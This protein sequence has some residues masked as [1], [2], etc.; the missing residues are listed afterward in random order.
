MGRPSPEQSYRVGTG[1]MVLDIRLLGIFD[2]LVDG[3]SVALGPA[4]QRALLASLAVD[5]GRPV[6]V[7]ALVDRIWDDAPPTEARKALHTYVTRTRRVLEQMRPAADGELDLQRRP[8]GYQL[9]VDPDLVDLHRFHRLVDRARGLD[10]HDPHRARLLAEAVDL[11]R[12]EALAGLSGAW[13]A[14]L[15]EGLGQQ[16]LSALADWAEAELAL[17]H[18]RVVIDRLQHVVPEHPLAE[19]LVARLIQALHMAGRDAEALDAYALARQRI[20]DG[21]GA[22]PGPELRRLHGAVLRGEPVVADAAPTASRP[23]AVAASPGAAGRRVPASAYRQLPPDIANFTGRRAEL[24]ALRSTATAT[25]GTAVAVSV[26]EGMAGVGK[27]KFAVHAAHRLVAEGR[28]PDGQIYVDLHGYSA[29]GPTDPAT[30]LALLLRL[31]GVATDDLPGDLAARSAVFRDRLAGRHT[32]II[33]D[34]AADET[35]LAPL[36]PGSPTCLVVVTSRRCLAIE[37]AQTIRLPA[38]TAD[39]AVDL[40]AAV[41]GVARVTAEPTAARELVAHCGHLPLAVAVAAQRLRNRPA[42]PI[43]HL[44]DRLADDHRRLD[45]L[46]QGNRAVEAV[47]ALSYNALGPDRRRLFRLLG[48]HPGHDFTAASAAALAGADPADVDRDLES[49][50]D[51][52][53]LQQ[54]VPGRYQIHDLLRGYAAR[55][56][57]AEDGDAAREAAISRLLDWYLHATDAAT[58]L[59]R[60]FAVPFTRAVAAPKAPGPDLTG[61]DDALDWLDTEYANLV[62]AAR[63]AAAGPWPAHAVQFPHL[64]LPY[65]VKRSQVEDWIALLHLAL[66][67]ADRLD[68]AHA[69]AHTLT[70]LG[71]ACNTAGRT[72]EGLA[73]LDQALD[74]H[75]RLGD[76]YGKAITLNHLGTVHRRLGDHA[77]AA[78]QYATALDL[79]R[80]TGDDVRQASTQSNLSVELHLLGRHEEALDHAGQALALQRR[81]GGPGEASLRT[82]LGL[83]YSRLGRHAEAV[84]HSLAALALHRRAASGPGETNALANLC[85]SYARLGEHDAA[86]EAGVRALDIARCLAD[87]DTVV[88]ALNTLGEAYHLAGDDS[89][90]LA[91]HREAL[92]VAV[93]IGDADERSRARLGMAAATRRSSAMTRR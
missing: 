81:L 92:A 5:A 37:G 88:V 12:G 73:H 25:P 20:A 78:D 31:L 54:S 76:A 21:I 70:D 84:E 1:A 7:E 89:R 64:L 27:T 56:C 47:F 63:T 55:R 93:R 50:L 74:L 69:R 6:V 65:L 30:V 52:H 3:R 26:V 85:H 33:L 60:R 17:G 44:R 75:D 62:A 22:E 59:I 46:V 13:A 41:A 58:S 9:V 2:V 34:N 19:S 86:V 29:V 4:K 14:R 79:F 53:L 77:R 91:H 28:Y 61:P 49:M 83:M 71:H 11:W 8:G 15:R 32:L 90:A 87:P 18:H 23:P 57:R 24:A 67:S 66:A 39:E 68:D 35:Q 10:R 38:F 43:G 36:L 40:L 82:N 42:W 72:E 45:E 80:R 48:E 16:R 51:E